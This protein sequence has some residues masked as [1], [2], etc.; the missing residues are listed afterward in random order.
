MEYAHMPPKMLQSNKEGCKRC[1]QQTGNDQ[2]I[3]SP[4]THRAI[5]LLHYTVDF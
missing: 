3:I 1:V 4:A 5:F 2:T